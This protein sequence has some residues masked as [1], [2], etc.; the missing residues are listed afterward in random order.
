MTQNASTSALDTNTASHQSSEA[1]IRISPQ[2]SEKMSVITTAVETSFTGLPDRSLPD[3]R[4]AKLPQLQTAASPH[5]T[6]DDD[7]VIVRFRNHLFIYFLLILTLNIINFMIGINIIVERNVVLY[8]R[9]ELNVNVFGM[10]YI[11]N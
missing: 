4:A 6:S 3:T 1:V 2:T 10:F 11:C 7:G 9:N 8:S 5:H